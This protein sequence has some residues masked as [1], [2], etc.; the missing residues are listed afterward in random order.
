VA[1]IGSSR[2]STHSVPPQLLASA[3]FSQDTKENAGNVLF[4]QP[5]QHFQI[6][7]ESEEKRMFSQHYVRTIAG[8]ISFHHHFIGRKI[9]VF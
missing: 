1:T 2:I 4:G 9:F 6:G 5:V 3:L 8:R 7:K